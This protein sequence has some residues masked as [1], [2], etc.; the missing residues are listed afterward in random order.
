MTDPGHVRPFAD[1]LREQA[2]GRTHDELTDA[3]ADVVAA[4]R[5]TGKKGS[6]TLTINVTPLK[7]G[8]GALTVTD[9]VKKT[10]PIHDRRASIFY[11]TPTG[12][13][14]KD[15]PNQPTFEGLQQVRAPTAPRIIDRQ[16]NHA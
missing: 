7:N 6:V 10:V 3:L 8:G 12:S 2:N 14:V 5:D 9:L 4:V 16:E 1:F 11:A 15:D 13:L